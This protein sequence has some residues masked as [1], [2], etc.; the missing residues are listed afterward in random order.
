MSPSHLRFDDQEVSDFIV[1]QR[2]LRKAEFSKSTI[3]F[4]SLSRQCKLYQHQINQWV[5]WGGM[6][7]KGEEANLYFHYPAQGQLS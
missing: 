4:A 2:P 6:K 3:L 5:G 7:G 1:Y